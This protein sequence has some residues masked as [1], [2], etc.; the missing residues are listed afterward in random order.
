MKKPIITNDN[1]VSRE[2]E[3]FFDTPTKQQLQHCGKQP[4]FTIVIG[5]R[6]ERGRAQNLMR[7]SYWLNP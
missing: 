7:H 3:G 4:R 1:Q 6:G 5:Q 2:V